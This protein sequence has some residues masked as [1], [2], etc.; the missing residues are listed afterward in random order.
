MAAYKK[1]TM[2][3]PIGSTGL[4]I[5]SS[6]KI[7]EPISSAASQLPAIGQSYNKM[8]GGGG[9]GGSMYSGGGSGGG[10]PSMMELEAS[11]MRLAD[12]ASRR[13]IAEKEAEAD[14]AARQEGFRSFDEKQR[15]AKR[16]RGFQSDF[17]NKMKNRPGKV[18]QSSD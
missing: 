2:S 15:Y 18:V 7:G 1:G 6:I 3:K 8:I 14:I 5:G 16:A 9:A 13:N 17:M 4:T 10:L 12:A 11:S